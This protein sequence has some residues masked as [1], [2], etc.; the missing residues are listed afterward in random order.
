MEKHSQRGSSTPVIAWH[1]YPPKNEKKNTTMVAEWSRWPYKEISHEQCW[2]RLKVKKNKKLWKLS[3]Q[4]SLKLVLIAHRDYS[5][6]HTHTFSGS[7]KNTYHFFFFF[8]VLLLEMTVT[9]GK[10]SGEVHLMLKSCLDRIFF[11]LML[12]LQLFL[13]NWWYNIWILGCW[14]KLSIKLLVYFHP[15]FH[16]S[17]AV[18]TEL[19]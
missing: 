1:H 11:S 5:Y 6:T 13:T 8:Y 16:T 19:V 18:C 12:W 7:E 4:S 14:Q 3:F 17:Q 10:L 9:N 15:P 2:L